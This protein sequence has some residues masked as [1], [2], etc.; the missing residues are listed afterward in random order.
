MVVVARGH[1]KR[2][3]GKEGAGAEG[4]G[5]GGAWSGEGDILRAVSSVVSAGCVVFAAPGVRY[6]DP[7]RGVF[8]SAGVRISAATPI[9]LLTSREPNDT[10]SRDFIAS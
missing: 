10:R 7:G 8:F 9:T 6:G 3:C 2:E 4:E 1:R 5:G